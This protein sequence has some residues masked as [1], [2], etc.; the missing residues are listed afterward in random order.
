VARGTSWSVVVSRNSKE[1]IFKHALST[2]Q[3]YRRIV[4]SFIAACFGAETPDWPSLTASTIT[5][6]VRQEAAVRQYAGR[7]YPAAAIRSFL[8]FLVFQG[9]VQPGLEAAALARL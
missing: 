8:R 5:V 9:E 6:F 3:G 2:R 1:G 7:Q 4:R